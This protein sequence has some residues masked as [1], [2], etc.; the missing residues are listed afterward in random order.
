MSKTYCAHAEVPWTKH[1]VLKY[2]EHLLQ[3]KTR[4]RFQQE[5]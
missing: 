5:L 3:Q 2:I 1:G 4:V